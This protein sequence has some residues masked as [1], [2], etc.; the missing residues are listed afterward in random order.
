M[1]GLAYETVWPKGRPQFSQDH[2]YQIARELTWLCHFT[3]DSD[4][5]PYFFKLR[6]SD[7]EEKI[8]I[9]VRK[10]GNLLVCEVVE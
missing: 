3:P 1:T 10:N 2:E 4:Y 6:E 5:V 8:N 9:R 7:G